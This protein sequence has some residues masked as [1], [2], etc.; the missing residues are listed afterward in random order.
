LEAIFNTTGV[1][2]VQHKF[3]KFLLGGIG[4]K[5]RL[6][7]LSADAQTIN[8]GKRDA[9]GDLRST[10]DIAD[11]EDFYSIPLSE[12]EK[13]TSGA[14]TKELQRALRRR[15]KGDAARAAASVRCFTIH[16]R[17][18]NRPAWDLEV[19]A[20]AL[21]AA[22]SDGAVLTQEKGEALRTTLVDFFISVAAIGSLDMG[23]SSSKAG[24]S[25][26]GGVVAEPNSAGSVGSNG[27]STAEPGSGGGVAAAASTDPRKSRTV[28]R[29]GGGS[30]GRNSGGGQEPP[31]PGTPSKKVGGSGLFKRR[32]STPS[33]KAGGG[34]LPDA[35]KKLSQK[36]KTFRQR[37][38]S[39]TVGDSDAMEDMVTDIL[40]EIEDEEGQGA[41]EEDGALYMAREMNP[42]RQAVTLA[43]EKGLPF[44]HRNCGTYS[45][46]GIEPKLTRTGFQVKAKINQDRGG[47]QFP[48]GGRPDMAF[49]CVMDG[50]GR[51]G[52]KISEYCMLQ[53][54]RL[55]LA[56]PS[57]ARN[58]GKALK[59]CFV[60]VDNELRA[61]LSREATYAGTTCVCV[62]VIGDVLVI[63]N[64]GDSRAVLGMVDDSNG[65]KLTS[66]DLSHDHKPDSPSETQ[67]VLGMGGF[68]SAESD[69]DG[70]SRVWLGR[71][72]NSCGLAM[73]RS[74]G[75]HALA[76]VGVIA[77]PEITT[78][79]FDYEKDRY[80]LL[81]S[82]GIWEFISS[83]QGVEIVHKVVTKDKEG[84]ADK[85]CRT[86]IERSSVAWKS[87][88]GDYRD[89]ITGIVV[90][91]PCFDPKLVTPMTPRTM[92]LVIGTKF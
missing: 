90:K 81:G 77:E 71:A 73:A 60:D 33:K 84:S 62:L 46:H 64:S 59:E 41:Q 12:M 51:G 87:H 16:W 6:L 1:P 47:I 76:A 44:E 80:L 30:V 13:I 38:L 57:L 2:V 22:E 3:R 26:A 40:K 48:F 15:N 34:G 4:W 32:S 52:E 18:S 35:N 17:G 74:L 11:D 19:D 70:P 9:S 39:I 65:G 37:K 78:H 72:M 50:H 92:N 36:E 68:V 23:S 86:L 29:G 10:G 75:D 21:P 8:L 55:L 88:E 7:T 25:A 61:K 43:N 56:H 89:D 27:G 24:S 31:S 14:E 67:R 66:K 20:A 54:P 63:A 42:N 49:F 28:G 58:P 5:P 83:Q 79:K 69:R 85:A 53:L 45:C 82:D 91:L